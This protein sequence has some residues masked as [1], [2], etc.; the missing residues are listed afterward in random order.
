[1]L[2][3]WRPL[4]LLTLS[5]LLF[6]CAGETL[7]SGQIRDCSENGIGCS[8]D[9]ACV[10]QDDGTHECVADDK[11]ASPPAEAAPASD[12]GASI[13]SATPVADAAITDA[14]VDAA[15]IADDD[16]D[17][18]PDGNDNCVNVPNPDQVDGDGDGLGDACDQDPAN[19]NYQLR[20]QMMTFGGRGVD[21]NNTL[22][23]KGTLGAQQGQSEN[24]QLKANL[25]Q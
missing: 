2:S 23:S 17:G 7:P 13:D 6:G 1:M 15:P 12:M 14:Q 10:E 9:F 22:H 24:Y 21:M 16:G 25:G 11:D 4:K 19:F 5:A 20:G 3:K 8:P 18:V